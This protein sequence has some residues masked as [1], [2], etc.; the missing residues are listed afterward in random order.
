MIVFTSV[1]T[2]LKDRF[3]SDLFSI[4][5]SGMKNGR[6]GKNLGPKQDCAISNSCY[7]GPCCSEVQVYLY[8]RWFPAVNY[9]GDSALF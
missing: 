1:L 2:R 7:N 6:L 8:I 9:I 5:S 4:I 3:F